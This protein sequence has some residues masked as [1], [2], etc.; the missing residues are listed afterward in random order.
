MMHK[1]VTSADVLKN[2]VHAV[3]DFSFF[4]TLRRYNTPQTVSFLSFFRTCAT[5]RTP[6]GTARARM[7][8]RSN[9]LKPA[10]SD[11]DSTHCA[12]QHGAH[13][14]AHRTTWR[15]HIVHTTQH[16]PH[17]V[18]TPHN[19]QST[20]NKSKMFN[21]ERINTFARADT[22][23]RIVRI[24]VLEKFRTLFLQLKSLCGVCS[25]HCDCEAFDAS[26]I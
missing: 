24:V 6:H 4:G 7:L 11:I 13:R 2:T 5:L 8:H 14:T 26:L 9:V 21:I 17:D 22:F 12:P 25:Q 3:S 23:R 15:M 18:R 19:V 10:M 16:T 1:I 20:T